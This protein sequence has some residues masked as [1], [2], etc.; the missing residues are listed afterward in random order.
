MQC[1]W[2]QNAASPPDY[3]ICQDLIIIN[4]EISYVFY[5]FSLKLN[6]KRFNLTVRRVL[7]LREAVL[8]HLGLDVLVRHPDGPVDE[9]Q[10]VRPILETRRPVKKVGRFLM[11][12]TDRDR[13]HEVQ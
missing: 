11:S 2:L 10:V 3:T 12:L 7:S 13:N 9:T 4:N 5:H 6:N 1:I 8:P